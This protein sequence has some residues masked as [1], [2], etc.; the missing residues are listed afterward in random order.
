MYKVVAGLLCLTFY[1]D[2]KCIWYWGCKV[3][4]PITSVPDLVLVVWVYFG[5]RSSEGHNKLSLWYFNWYI[6][7]GNFTLYYL[8]SDQYI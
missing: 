8:G 2:T 3:F 6:F 7:Y 1:L 5:H 4:A